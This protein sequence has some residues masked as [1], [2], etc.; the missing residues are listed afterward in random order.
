[1]VT[2]FW[3]NGLR[4]GSGKKH[5]PDRVNGYPRMER[6]MSRFPFF[7]FSISLDPVTIRSFFLNIEISLNH[8]PLS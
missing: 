3:Y 4:V 6:Y 2:Y 1:M 5:Q 7:P 8:D